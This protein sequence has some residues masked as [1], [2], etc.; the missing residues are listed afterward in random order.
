MFLLKTI[1]LERFRWRQFMFAHGWRRRSA[2]IASYIILCIPFIF[3]SKM[4]LPETQNNVI[5]AIDFSA[6]LHRSKRQIFIF[7]IMRWY[8]RAR[9]KKLNFS[10]VANLLGKWV[11]AIAGITTNKLWNCFF[12]LQRVASS[13]PFFINFYDLSTKDP[14]KRVMMLANGCKHILSASRKNWR[15]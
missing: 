1:S 14:L 3:A 7:M 11:V 13:Q 8:Q 2:H 4:S 15:P 12:G 10:R 9:E 6:F 5:T